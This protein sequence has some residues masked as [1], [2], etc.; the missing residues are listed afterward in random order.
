[1]SHSLERP[2]S[3]A[4][5]VHPIGEQ[6]FL[7]QDPAGHQE[8]TIQVS[9]VAL[10]LL[11]LCDGQRDRAAIQEE[12]QKQTGM[13]LPSEQLADFV[14]QMD[15]S[16]LLDSP[17]FREHVQEL[18]RT[19][20]GQ[21]WRDATHAGGAYD[22]DPATLATDLDRHLDGGRATPVREAPLVGLLAPHID[23]HRGGAGYGKAYAALRHHQ[24]PDVVVILGTAHSGAG[25]RF[26]ICDKGYRTPRGDLDVDRDFLAS[27][28]AGLGRDHREDMLVHRTEHSIEFQA[29]F[30]AHLYADQSLPSIVPILCTTV[31][32]CMASGRSPRDVP[33]IQDFLAALQSAYQAEERRV[34]VVGG[35]DFSHVGPRFGDEV[36]L[37]EAFLAGVRANDEAAIAG[38]V[39]ASAADFYAAVGRHENSNRIC[40]VSAIYSV[41]DTVPARSGELLV[42][43]QAVD[44]AGQL[45]VTYAGIALYGDAE[46]PGL[47][48]NPVTA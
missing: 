33:E 22:A 5:E 38:I 27:L 29:L 20:L 10:F 12:F 24:P 30:L 17:S 31:E 16:M 44:P 7:L 43:D 41:L 34:L 4:L 9:A 6:G 48:R 11:G 46:G 26:V 32:D 35:V 47:P 40:S 18:K 23:L 25:R 2:K 37:D 45:A 21:R 39:D 1:M 3:R 15:Q 28:E 19:F 13:Q 36:T 42:Y 14:R 8:S